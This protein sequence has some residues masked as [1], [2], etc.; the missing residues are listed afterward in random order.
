MSVTDAVSL[1]FLARFGVQLRPSPRAPLPTP[2]YLPR[3]LEGGE[4]AQYSQ[5][6]QLMLSQ[7]NPSQVGQRSSAVA[8]RAGQ[9]V[10]TLSPAPST[11]RCRVTPAPCTR[12]AALFAA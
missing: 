2:L 3:L 4:R 5:G 1:S 11:Y 6:I 10:L 9:S 12:T 7:L 8:A